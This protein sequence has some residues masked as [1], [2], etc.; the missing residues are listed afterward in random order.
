MTLYWC[1][2]KKPTPNFRQMIYWI[3]VIIALLLPTAMYCILYFIFKKLKTRAG[4]FL[5]NKSSWSWILE[6]SE[7]ADNTWILKFLFCRI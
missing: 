2:F 1:R 4:C 5:Q 7:M 6:I 3:F